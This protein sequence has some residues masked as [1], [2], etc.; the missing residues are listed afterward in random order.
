M[1]DNFQRSQTRLAVPCFSFPYLLTRTTIWEGRAPIRK[2]H[3][4]VETGTVYGNER[5][6]SLVAIDGS[7][8]KAVN[9]HNRN[10]TSAK[11]ERR[12]RHIESSIARYLA[13][14]DTADRQEPAIAKARTERLQEK[15]AALK[16][17]MQSLKE[18]ER[19]DTRMP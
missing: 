16:E 1:E 17:Q 19:G 11:L 9:H 6:V 8:S 7:K 12:M 10:F 15:I 3:R 4:R 2:F 14:M 18:Q 13:A 5:P